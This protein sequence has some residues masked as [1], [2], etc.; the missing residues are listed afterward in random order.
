MARVRRITMLAAVYLLLGS[1]VSV[2]VAWGFAAQFPWTYWARED[3]P[4]AAAAV[5]DEPLPMWAYEA[6]GLPM[7]NPDRFARVDTVAFGFTSTE[8]EAWRAPVVVPTGQQLY[9]DL[10]WIPEEKT[11]VDSSGMLSSLR[12]AYGWPWRAMVRHEYRYYE[13]PWSEPVPDFPGMGS[14]HRHNDQLPAVIRTGWH[15]FNLP[16]GSYTH[17]VRLPLQPLWLGMAANSGFYAGVL[18][19]VLVIPGVIRRAI[20]ARRLR[21]GLC[22]SCRYPRGVAAVCSECGEK[23]TL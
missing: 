22:P 1:V 10:G 17:P 7:V 12:F 14:S 16:N 23:V 20:R 8:V 3:G 2:A 9:T 19:C 21:A 5:L 15:A 13:P 6:F 18:A 4:R 11:T